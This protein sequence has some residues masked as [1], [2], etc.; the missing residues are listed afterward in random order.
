MNFKSYQVGKYISKQVTEV[1]WFKLMIPLISTFR[2]GSV[3][4]EKE[5]K[6]INSDRLFIGRL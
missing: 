6:K 1:S 5:S 3:R 4:A 2:E